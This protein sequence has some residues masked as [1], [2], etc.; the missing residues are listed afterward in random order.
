MRETRRERETGVSLLMT[1]TPNGEDKLKINYG[2]WKMILRHSSERDEAALV[3][4]SVGSSFREGL[5]VIP[6]AI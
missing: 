5:L 2:R 6:V 1:K 4:E 3:G